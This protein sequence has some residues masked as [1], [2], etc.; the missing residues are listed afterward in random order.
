MSNKQSVLIMFKTPWCKPCKTME[1]VLSDVLIE[2]NNI[3][4]ININVDEEPDMAREYHV[5]TVPTLIL[6]DGNKVERLIGSA[7]IK[8]VK[9]FLSK[10]I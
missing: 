8:Q 9:S 1:T 4:F 10:H 2:F 3:K 7:N 5:R 6:E